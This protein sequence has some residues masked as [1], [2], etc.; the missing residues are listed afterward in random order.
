MNKKSLHTSSNNEKRTRDEPNCS[1]SKRVR[2]NVSKEPELK[3]KQVQSPGPDTGE[4]NTNKVAT[5]VI[6]NGLR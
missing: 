5:Q 6:N 1:E 3:M 4:I 2:F